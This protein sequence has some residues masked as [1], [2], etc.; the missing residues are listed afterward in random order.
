M[1][2]KGGEDSEV[3]SEEEQRGQ[4]RRMKRSSKK[5]KEV[6]DE[7]RTRNGEG[8]CTVTSYHRSGKIHC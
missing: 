1:Q 2:Q 4:Q 7:S 8:T 6:Q 5:F 3:G